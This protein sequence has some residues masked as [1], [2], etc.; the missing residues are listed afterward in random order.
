MNTWLA[1]KWSESFMDKVAKT[2][3]V[4]IVNSFSEDRLAGPL[5]A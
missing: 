2:M 3:E 1:C 4:L 5:A